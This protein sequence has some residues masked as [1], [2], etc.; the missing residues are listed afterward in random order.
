M[1][2][3]Y[4]TIEEASNITGENIETIRKRCQASKIIGAQNK[5]K[6]WLIPKS[7]VFK[8]KIRKPPIPLLW[9]DTWVILRLTKA[10]KS[11]LATKEEKIWGEEI[12]DKITTLTDKKKILCPEADQGIEIETGGRLVNEARE[13]QAQISRGVTIYYHQAVED[14]QI[15]RIMKAYAEKKVEAVLPWQDLF[16]EDPVKEIERNNPYIISVHGNPPKKELEDRK[17][18]SRSVADD[19]EAIRLE[20]NRKKEKFDVRLQLEQAARGNLI[21]KFAAF[22]VAKRIHK[23]EV[24]TDE[25]IKAMNIMGKPLA[26]WKGDGKKA[27]DLFGLIQ[28]YLSEEFKKI[29]AI[30]ISSNLVSKLVT[31]HEKIRPSDVMDVNQIS[32]VLPYAHYMVLDGPMRDKIMYKLK[33]DKKYQ[34]KILKLKDLPDLLQKLS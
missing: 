11:N 17:R 15:Q 1:D 32:A 25:L 12:F 8:V 16:F 6:T 29:P 10:V 5:G 33:L 34:T 19:W 22:L 26:W 3:E 2:I 18:T 24:S 28:F 4:L 13:L 31:D 20:S 9:L 14:L 30:D 23:K 27:E 7:Y 21:M